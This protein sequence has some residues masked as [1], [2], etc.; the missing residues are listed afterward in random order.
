MLGRTEAHTPG[1]PGVAFEQAG[2]AVHKKVVEVGSRE[3]IELG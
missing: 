1:K 3:G 2:L